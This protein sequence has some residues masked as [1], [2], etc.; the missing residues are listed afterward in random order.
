MDFPAP[1]DDD[2]NDYVSDSNSESS[3]SDYDLYSNEDSDFDSD[4]DNGTI[5]FT[6]PDVKSNPPSWT[7]DVQTITV[8]PFK[9]TGGPTLPRDFNVNTTHPIDY[10]KLFLQ[11]QLLS[12]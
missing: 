1:A 6:V 11:M 12:I 8:P 10:F 9:F 4:T 3:E 5:D 2:A 7:D